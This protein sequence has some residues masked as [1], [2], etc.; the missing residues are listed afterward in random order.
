MSKTN[1]LKI[2]VYQKGDMGYVA[3]AL[4]ANYTFHFV[5]VDNESAAFEQLQKELKDMY[6][7]WH[8]DASIY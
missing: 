2:R 1:E 5:I 6:C 3:D 8:K 4:L 7:T